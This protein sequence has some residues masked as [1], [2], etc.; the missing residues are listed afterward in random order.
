MIVG[1]TIGVLGDPQVGLTWSG[2]NRTE[3]ILAI[4]NYFSDMA[5]SKKWDACVCLGDLFDSARPD[6]LDVASVIRWLNRFEAASIPLFVL[7]GNHDGNALVPISEFPYRSVRFISSPI[8]CTLR[9]RSLFFVPF[10]RAKELGRWKESVVLP[11]DS[12]TGFCHL[13]IGGALSGVES[14]WLKSS[15]EKLPEE[16]VDDPKARMW[17]AG[18]FHT[19][20]QVNKVTI[21]G[22]LVQVDMSEVSDEKRFV[23]VDLGTE[24]IS[25]YPVNQSSLSSRLQRLSFDLT[26][27]ADRS[28]FNQFMTDP[29]KVVSPS[30]LLSLDLQ[31]PETDS[32][33][34]IKQVEAALKPFVR[35]LRPVS[36]VYIRRQ[37]A[38]LPVVT[39]KLRPIDAVNKYIESYWKNTETVDAVR[40]KT[41][42]ALDKGVPV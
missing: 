5:E 29:A 12:Y 36:P 40:N 30:T 6:P 39:A 25:Y 31:I 19:P 22:S 26:Q 42:L 16:W 32:E 3:E 34:D 15:P 18:H 1:P 17:F 10:A 11:T 9:G 38:R 4:M 7:R 35:F 21:V 20:Q 33:L 13:G 28:R 23:S 41:M 37:E 27:E 8:G 24:E 14:F 2:L